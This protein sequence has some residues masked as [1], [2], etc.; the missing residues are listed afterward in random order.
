MKCVRGFKD[1]T[2]L[3]ARN[4][5]FVLPEAS[6]KL[7]ERLQELF[8]TADPVLAVSQIVSEVQR[9]GDAALRGYTA[10]IDGITLNVLEVPAQEIVASVEQ[11]ASQTISDLK[12]VASQVWSFHE[13]QREA[14]LTGVARMDPGTV[15]RILKRVG[16]YVPGGMASYPSSVL[17]TAIPAKVAGVEEVVIATPPGKDGKVPVR[18]LA[19]AAIAGA[20]RVFAIGGA[21]AVAALACGTESVPKV[22][23]ICGPGNLFVML[24]K[25]QLYGAVDIDGLQGPSEVVVIADDKANPSWVTWD[26]LAQAEHDPL[27]QSVLIT[28]SEALAQAVQK[29]VENELPRQERRAIIEESLVSRGIIAVVASLD[30]AFALSNLYAPEHLCL[31]LEDAGKYVSRIEHAGCVFIG[32]HPTVVM[33]D[34]VAGPS[35]A[36]PT[37]GTARFASPLNVTDFIRLMNVVNVDGEMRRSFADVAVSLAQA[38]GLMA[39]ARALTTDNEEDGNA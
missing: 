31:Y 24:A 35:H 23:K 17:M 5:G 12:I 27:A 22:D 30:E 20:D 7:K 15:A 21:Q 6:P 29:M 14:F 32:T 39:H 3:L 34:Y 33:G 28:T 36:L 37:S 8:G 2:E 38:E 25:K 18:T 11:V 9:N 19:A 10:Q 16:L 26:I 1:A 4:A 13:K